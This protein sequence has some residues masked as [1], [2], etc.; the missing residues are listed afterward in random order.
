MTAADEP[1]EPNERPA[2]RG[3]L[4]L[5]LIVIGL[6]ATVLATLIG[7]AAGTVWLRLFGAG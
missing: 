1:P 5:D 6:L 2:P 3:D 4:P 7:V